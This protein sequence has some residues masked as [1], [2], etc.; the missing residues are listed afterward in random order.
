MR[1]ALAVKLYKEGALTLGKAAKLADQSLEG[2]IERLGKLGVSIVDY[3]ADE[4]N[5]ELKDFE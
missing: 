5:K 2:F 4:L 1:P 3:T